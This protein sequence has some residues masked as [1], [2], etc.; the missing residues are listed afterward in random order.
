MEWQLGQLCSS[1]PSALPQKHALL[2][3]C[4]LILKAHLE[5]TRKREPKEPA[6]GP[7]QGVL[8]NQGGAAQSF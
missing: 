7:S 5:P 8:V 2:D 6:P 3:F 4:Y 1:V